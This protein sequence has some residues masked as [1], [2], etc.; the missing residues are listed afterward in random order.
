M[1]WKIYVLYREYILVY[2]LIKFYTKILLLY[3]NKD[4]IS[5]GTLLR[6]LRYEKMHVHFKISTPN[7]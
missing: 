7:D 5:E 1:L 2:I 3:L 6:I 4:I